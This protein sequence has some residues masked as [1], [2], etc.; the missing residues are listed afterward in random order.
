MDKDEVAK[1]VKIFREAIIHY[2]VS[3]YRIL[4]S[5]TIDKGGQISQQQA[6]YGQIT[7]LAVRIP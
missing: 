3:R 6:I 7:S 5:G 2:Q 1:V 4:V